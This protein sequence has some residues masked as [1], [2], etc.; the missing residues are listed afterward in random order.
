[1]KIKDDLISRREALSKAELIFDEDGNMIEC[2]RVRN[3]MDLPC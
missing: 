3:I 2:V 1:M